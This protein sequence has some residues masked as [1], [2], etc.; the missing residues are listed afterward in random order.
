MGLA[1]GTGGPGACAGLQLGRLGHDTATRVLP[2]CGTAPGATC[3]A[4]AERRRVKIAIDARELRDKPTGVGRFLAEILAG[5]KTM[6]EAQAREFLLL[7]PDG[8][9]PRKGILW[10]QVVL[11]RLVREAR[12]DVLFSP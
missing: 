3:L 11:P 7:A 12:S 10:E 1:A 9:T 6:P 8:V 4:T 2:R 5:W